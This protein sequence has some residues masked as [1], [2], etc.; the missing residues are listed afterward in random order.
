MYRILKPGGIL[1]VVDSFRTPHPLSYMVNKLYRRFSIEFG[2]AN[3]AV[4]TDF[5]K[6]LKNKGFNDV[7]IKDIS[8]KVRRSVFQF[9]MLA[10]PY[11]VSKTIRKRFYFK[12]RSSKDKLRD[13]YQGNAVI[14]GVCGLLGAIS[15]YGT[16]AKKP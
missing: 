14:A 16:S 10:A 12:K 9:G 5:E 13:Y 3:L 4:I 11:Y 7:R 6:Y 15:Y 1:V 2:Y 8:K